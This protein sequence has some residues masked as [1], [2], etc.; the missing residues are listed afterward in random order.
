MID[1]IISSS[2]GSI[3]SRLICHPIDTVKARFQLPNSTYKSTWEIAKVTLKEEGIRGFYRGVGTVTGLGTPAFILYL[4]TYEQCKTY[5]ATIGTT[6]AI[7]TAS[8]SSEENELSFLQKYPFLNHFA[9]GMIAESVSCLVYVPVDVVKERLQIQ[10]NLKDGTLVKGNLPTY[11]KGTLH[12][13]Q[14]IFQQE[15]L[16][17]V[18]KGYGATLLSFGP[19]SAF[20]FLFYEQWK[21]TGQDYFYAKLKE[22]TQDKEIGLTTRAKQGQDQDKVSQN[23]LSDIKSP[24]HVTLPFWYTLFAAAMAGAMASFVTNPLDLIR[25]RLQVQR[26]GEIEATR[27]QKINLDAPEKAM[28]ADSTTAYKN[29]WDGLTKIYKHDGIRGLF[30]GV[31]AR[32]L[33]HTPSTMISMTCY[34]QSKKVF[35]SKN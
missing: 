35:F 17:G 27:Q 15:G 2:I 14:K 11:Y 29:S 7:S 4:C 12:A 26:G 3:V 34:E 6:S 1:T 20:Y 33:F 23:I 19:F 30:R 8:N 10:R 13:L 25:L 18:Y 5:F 16:R 21:K 31:N 32:I 9:S 28:T 24:E 22:S